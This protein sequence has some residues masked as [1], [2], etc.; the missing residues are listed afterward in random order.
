MKIRMAFTFLLIF[1]VSVMGV[2]HADAQTTKW[3]DQNY[4]SDGNDGNSEATAYA[5]LQFAIDSS[6]SGTSDSDRSVIY[7]KNGAYATTGQTNQ[8]G[9]ST[10]ILIENLS[11]LTIQAAPGNNPS[12]RP[13][14]GNNVSISVQGG[15]HLIVDNIDSDQTVA[16]FDGW[17]V[18]S[19]DNLTVKNSTF[20]GG[21]DGIDF[22]EAIDGVL[23]E[24]NVF[25]NIT[26]GS[27][28]E[29]LD[30]SDADAGNV[31]IQ[32]NLF[33]NNYRHIRTGDPDDGG[34]ASNM[35]IRRNTFNGTNSQE[36]VRLIGA[37]GVVLENNLFLNNRQQGLYIDSGCSDIAV[38]HNTFFNNDQEG[39]GHGE[40]RT[41]V[42][43]SDIVIQNNIFY[44]N[45]S[46][47]AFETSA[48]SLPGEDWNRTFNTVD[49][50][51]TFGGNTATN[52]DPLFVS[53][54]AGAEDLHLQAGS[55]ALEAGPDLGV[56]DDNEKNSRPQPSGTDPDQGAYEMDSTMGGAQE[57]PAVAFWQIILLVALLSLVLW[58]KSRKTA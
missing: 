20:E 43:D 25:K 58:R 56:T 21:E 40:I 18:F 2:M 36:A 46:N 52:S 38:R 28:D 39:V 53:T 1:A 7:V 11:Y 57:V 10:A 12:V 17:H 22:N 23:I 4:G 19:H 8:G 42:S 14:A 41:K 44:G 37:A 24:N 30:F 55:P 5:T 15:S 54:T 27:G 13:A 9:Y 47:P 31:T 35:I 29:V 50:G 51:F 34:V 45:G 26:T 16:Q 3:V 6:T 48:A 33:Q 32:D 49:T